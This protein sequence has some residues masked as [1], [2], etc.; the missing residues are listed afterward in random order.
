[1]VFLW[2]GVVCFYSGFSFAQNVPEHFGQAKYYAKKIFSDHRETFYCGCHY[3]K[4]QHID[5]NSCGYQIQKDKRRARRLEWEH[6]V[7]VSLWNNHFPCWKQAI[8][9]EKKRCYKGRECCRKKDKSF[10]KMEA[11]LHNLVPEIGEINQLRSNYRFGL[12]PHIE[13]GQFGSCEFKIDRTTRRVEPRVAV[14]GIIA[15]AYLYM[16]KTYHIAL[17]KSQ[18]QLYVS[19]NRLYPPDSWEREWDDRVAEIQGNHNTYITQYQENR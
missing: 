7:P 6:I 17:S 11:D 14:R 3:D 4:H 2:V 16:A 1:M 19:W 8:C 18:Q 12:L 10:A 5:L 9:C 13:A 15:R